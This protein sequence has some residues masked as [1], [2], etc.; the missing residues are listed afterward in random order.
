MNILIN[1]QK[2]VFYPLKRYSRLFEKMGQPKSDL[3]VKSQTD[4]NR[5]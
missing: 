4:L 5:T 1:V 2:I 3:R